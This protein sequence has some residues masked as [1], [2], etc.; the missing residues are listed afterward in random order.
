VLTTVAG[1]PVRDLVQLQQ[2]LNDT[3][4]D[5]CDVQFSPPKGQITQAS[6]AN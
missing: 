3:P 6:V 4:A 5:Q 2:V 1:K